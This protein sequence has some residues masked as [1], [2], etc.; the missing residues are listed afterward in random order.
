MPQYTLTSEGINNYFEEAYESMFS[1]KP[2]HHYEKSENFF[3]CVKNE[4]EVEISDH[5]YDYHD[6]L[7]KLNDDHNKKKLWELRLRN[8][9]NMLYNII[10][11]HGEFEYIILGI[12]GSNKVIK[13]NF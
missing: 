6:I 9:C 2:T 8:V 4:L 1:V 10:K 11:H 13:I 7:K 5:E 3:A 12:F